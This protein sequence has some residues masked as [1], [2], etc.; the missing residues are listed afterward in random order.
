MKIIFINYILSMTNQNVEKSTNHG[1][2]HMIKV[3]VVLTTYKIKS[4]GQYFQ[5]Q[6]FTAS[7][8]L[9]TSSN[10]ALKQFYFLFESEA[11]LFTYIVIYSNYWFIS[12][13]ILF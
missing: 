11:R 2:Q 7:H 9:F 4:T 10:Q 13:L 1:K 8:V 6:M 3:P 12:L 5:S